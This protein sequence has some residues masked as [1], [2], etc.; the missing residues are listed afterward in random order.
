VVEGRD[1]GTVVFPA[2]DLKIWLDASPEERARRRAAE[3]G[4]DSSAV[5]QSLEQ[6]DRRDSTRASSPQRPA[7]D[8]VLVDTTG[9]TAEETVELV[10]A[11]VAER[12]AGV[13]AEP[14]R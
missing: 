7:D 3:A 13:E 11:L 9:M 2:A 8:A 5:K 10:M 12:T 14:P 4:A 6:R 1:I